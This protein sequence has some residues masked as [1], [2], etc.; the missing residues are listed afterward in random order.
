MSEYIAADVI[1]SLNRTYKLQKKFTEIIVEKLGINPSQQKILMYLADNENFSP[2]Q[3]EIAEKFE[4]SPAAVAVMIKKMSNAGL[5]KKTIF[6]KDNRINNITLTDKAKKIACEIK[7][8]TESMQNQMF[9]DFSETEIYEF[10]RLLKKMQ[11]SVD[12]HFKTYI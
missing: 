11:L 2:S 7:Q 3:K 9:K 6:D 1:I 8:H 5:V 10:C 4:I 12:E